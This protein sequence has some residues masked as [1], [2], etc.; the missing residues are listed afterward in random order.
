M[1]ASTARTYL[2]GHGACL[3]E[4]H[5]ERLG[6][7]A[8]GTGWGAGGQS[9]ERQAEQGQLRAGGSSRSRRSQKSGRGRGATVVPPPPPGW[10]LVGRE[11]WAGEKDMAGG[12]LAERADASRPGG[13]AQ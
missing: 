3:V 12:W 1:T 13:G 5:A 8:G 9:K 11:K 4:G 7:M 2:Q 10:A 6:C